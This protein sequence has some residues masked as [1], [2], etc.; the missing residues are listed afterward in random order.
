[1]SN[2]SEDFW[3]NISDGLILRSS[4][5]DGL[6]S[7]SLRIG[8]EDSVGTVGGSIGAARRGNLGG[9]LWKA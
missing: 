7:E 2:E 5:L 8:D 1:M 6:S 3:R 4:E 9:G